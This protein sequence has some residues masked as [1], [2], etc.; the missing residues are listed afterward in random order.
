M[1]D[2]IIQTIVV[3]DRLESYKT[4]FD[5]AWA[6]NLGGLVR[7]TKLDLPFGNLCVNWKAAANTCV[8]PWL[9][10]TSV[11]EFSVGFTMGREPFA[12]Q[13]IDACAR[14]LPDEMPSLS[15]MRRKEMR[16]AIRRIGTELN[17]VLAQQA[18]E[19]TVDADQMWTVFMNGVAAHEF[20]LSIWG[21]QRI[22]CGALYHAYENFVREAVGL[23]LGV[24][25]YKAGHISVFLKDCA[26]SLGKPI[27]DYCL[28]D[29]D[30]QTARLVR[31]AL[32]HNGG[33]ETSQLQKVAHGIRVEDGKLQIMAPDTRRLFD[34][35]KVRVSKLAEEAI[36]LPSIS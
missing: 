18:H 6:T 14:R 1:S 20:R 8:L 21:S 12:A 23:A 35:L 30:V 7:D 17:T 2:D 9:M 31:N 26:R 19:F 27:A 22:S 33:T 10:C 11:A 24:A 34:L 5:P 32:A 28:A 36:T 16:E 13:V 29:A 15:N 25:N 4:F 3:D